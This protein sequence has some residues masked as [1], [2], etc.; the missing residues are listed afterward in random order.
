MKI[1]KKYLAI[2]LI[3]ISILTFSVVKK[4]FENDAFYTIALGELVLENGIDMQDH[5][6]FVKGLSYTYPHWLFDSIVSIFYKV[7]DLAG[8]YLFTVIMSIVFSITMFIIMKK[9]KTNTTIAF[10]VTLCAIQLLSNLFV[11]RAQ[12]VS[13][14]FLLIEFY[15]L[16]AL[17]EEKKFSHVLLL[18]AIPIII[19]NI[20][21]AVWYI[22]FIMYLPYFA[23][24]F[25]EYNSLPNSITR[26][27][28]KLELK[29]EKLKD[30][31]FKKK[32]V[33]ELEKQLNYY[34]KYLTEK[35]K[36]KSEPKFYA[37]K[38]SNL[39][40]MIALFVISLATGLITPIG[41]TPY[42][43]FIKNTMGSSFKYISEQARIVVAERLDFQIMF[44][45]LMAIIGFTKT[46]VRLKDTFYIVGFCVLAILST[47][48]VLFFVI[49]G[50]V[51]LARLITEFF[52]INNIDLEK[53]DKSMTK[54]ISLG[55][56][57]AVIGFTAVINYATI[58][59]Q[60]YA[61][62]TLYP[63]KAADYIVEKLDYKKIRLYN[64]YDYGS[65]LLF[66]DIPV[67]VDSRSELYC[68]EFND[69]SIFDDYISVSFGKKHYKEVFD[70]YDITH[71]L[72][73]K[74]SIESI[75]ISKDNNYKLLYEDEIFV[76]YEN[77]K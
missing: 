76:L 41:D 3:C 13:Y 38:N 54:N 49:F 46:R 8:V 62:E 26:K 66:R 53:I 5:F 44:I 75:Y 27:K 73:K 10:F 65:Y 58:V 22:Y 19:A 11:G 39:K 69:T 20:H 42:T 51:I 23:E 55:C 48:S 71:I 29:I 30:N 21:S 6:C 12:L 31:N 35:A 16:D 50:M 37:K 15:A 56:I 57:V 52:E 25:L 7:W 2:I 9:R 17:A 64:N 18:I 74:D 60:Q 32:E 34:N 33:K 40:L 77:T 14:L 4:T 28:E 70:K 67:F 45:S 63:V 47:R 1:N 24:A 68:E 36:E 59:N 61:D 72:V 43:Y